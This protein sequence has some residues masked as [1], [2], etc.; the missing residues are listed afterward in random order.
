MHFESIER[1]ILEIEE[2]VRESE[3]KLQKEPCSAAKISSPRLRSVETPR[4][5][6]RTPYYLSDP[7]SEITQLE[8]EF[9]KAGKQY[10][11]QDING[12]DFD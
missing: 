9:Q 4:S 11:A 1:P 12:W 5:T 3:D 10:S 7:E 6:P 8:L 2:T